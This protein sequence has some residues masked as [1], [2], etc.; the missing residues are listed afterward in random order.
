MGSDPLCRLWAK[1]QVDQSGDMRDLKKWRTV[2]RLMLTIL[3]LTLMT[4]AQSVTT[5][6]ITEDATPKPPG[7]DTTK[8]QSASPVVLIATYQ[9]YSGLRRGREQEMA[10][11]VCTV[12]AGDLYCPNFNDSRHPDRFAAVEFELNRQPGFTVRY[13]EGNHYRARSSGTP[14]ESGGN[15]VVLLKLR[16][17]GDVPLGA[18]VLTGRMKFRKGDQGPGG[19]WSGNGALEEIEVKIPIVVVGHDDMVSQ[20]TVWLRDEGIGQK[21]AQGMQDLAAGIPALFI[22]VFGDCR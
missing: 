19:A 13:R 10:V 12:P 6:A 17:L 5:T 18:H 1:Y 14:F 4:P 22:C 2:R 20:N 7:T 11:V 3:A 9:R 8:P 15:D 16:T 21:M